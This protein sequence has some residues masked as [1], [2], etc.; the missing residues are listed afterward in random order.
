LAFC[1]NPSRLLKSSFQL[2]A[3]AMPSVLLL[4]LL[5]PTSPGLELLVADGNP[6]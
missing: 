3:P 2:L 5:L 1:F 4:V 6:F